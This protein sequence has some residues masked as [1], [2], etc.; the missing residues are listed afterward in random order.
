MKG[1][2]GARGRWGRGRRAGC[3]GRIHP[4]RV[5]RSYLFDWRVPD[6]GAPARVGSGKQL[7]AQAAPWPLELTRLA[8][9]LR[10]GVGPGNTWGEDQQRAMCG[11]VGYLD[12]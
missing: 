10:P 4:G 11:I 8:K 1:A 5:G 7:L 6:S 3:E 2:A 9:R 12:K